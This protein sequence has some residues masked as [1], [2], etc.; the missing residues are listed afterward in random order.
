MARYVRHHAEQALLGLAAFSYEA[1]DALHREMTVEAVHGA[2]TS[3][4]RLRAT[5]HSFPGSF[6]DPAAT[7]AD[8]RAVARS[9][10]AVRDIDVI[11]AHL[12]EE[13]EA[14]PPELV[15]GPVRDDL[16]E[17]LAARRRAAVAIVDRE[18][19][20]KAWG[21]AVKQLGAWQ[22]TPPRLTEKDPLLV[23]KQVREDVLA[24]VRESEG[25]P[26]ALHSARKAAK[27]W[28]YAA[29]LLVPDLPKAGKHFDRATQFHVL[30]GEM[31][32]AVVTAQFL[33][34][35]ARLGNRSGHNG[36]TTGVLHER[37]RQRRDR[38]VDQALRLA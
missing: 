17:S 38:T 10:S 12:R 2:R 37:A 24:R 13:L 7:D 27:R 34:E 6:T 23:L 20:G 33:L 11:G 35:H 29:E 36:F 32:D 30:L 25:D 9:L 1:G 5:L 28:R 14:L 18:R 31:Q 19:T 15:L 8:L 22:R 4:R 21:R 3:L 16:E 26:T